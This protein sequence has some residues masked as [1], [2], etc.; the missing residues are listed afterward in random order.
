MSEF[1]VKFKDFHSKQKAKE[2]ID[3]LFN[4]PDNINVNYVKGI[5]DLDINNDN[6]R[7]AQ[8]IGLFYLGQLYNKEISEAIRYSDLNKSQLKSFISGLSVNENIESVINTIDNE[9]DLITL[10]ESSIIVTSLENSKKIEEAYKERGY[11]EEKLLLTKYNLLEVGSICLNSQLVNSV[12]QVSNK[13]DR[14]EMVEYSLRLSLN[15]DDFFKMNNRDDL[16]DYYKN[17]KSSLEYSNTTEDEKRKNFVNML[18][19]NY[20]EEMN[21][22]KVSNNI[23]NDKKGLFSFS[24][25]F[26]ISNLSILNKPVENFKNK[27]KNIGDYI[28]E[29]KEQYI[30]RI[31]EKTKGDTNLLDDEK[32]EIIKQKIEEIK[33]ND[34]KESLRSIL[35]LSKNVLSNIIDTIQENNTSTLFTY[36]LLDLCKKRMN[37]EEIEQVQQINLKD[38]QNIVSKK[39]IE[40][41]E[42]IAKSM[43]EVLYKT[44]TVIINMN[45]KV[46]DNVLKIER[47]ADENINNMMSWYKNNKDAI[48]NTIQQNKDNTLT[49]LNAIGDSTIKEILTEGLISRIKKAKEKNNQTSENKNDFSI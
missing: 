2:T 42:S 45:E 12:L 22:Q 8:E 31:I 37:K 7:Y 26:D 38:V 29:R 43:N 44:E 13:E 40:V 41:N 11:D 46:M 25:Y 17:F 19:S 15:Q 33:N 34:K 27:I 4:D 20:K 10:Y 18:S 28:T 23:T 35:S 3:I 16:L 48:N 32:V 24:Q 47:K 6:N 5:L 30:S 21:L 1:K 14:L 39:T 36:G 49:A 9:E